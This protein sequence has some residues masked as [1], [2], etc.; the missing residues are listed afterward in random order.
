MSNPS[1]TELLRDKQLLLQEIIDLLEI[2]HEALRNDT[3]TCFY[4]DERRNDIK[5]CEET[6]RNSRKSARE[7]CLNYLS[8]DP[9]TNRITIKEDDILKYNNLIQQTIKLNY[10]KWIAIEMKVFDCCHRHNH[11]INSIYPP[12][13]EQRLSALKAKLRKTAGELQKY[14]KQKRK[15]AKSSQS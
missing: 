5:S 15:E 12:E 4:N 9:Q 1:E 8:R 14:Q 13:N 11:Q 6:I 7:N 3:I 2:K 10:E